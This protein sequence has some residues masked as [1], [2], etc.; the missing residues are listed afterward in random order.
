MNILVTGATGFIGASFTRLALSQGLAVRATGRRPERLA[1]LARLGAQVMEGDLADADFAR[2]L[3][4]GVEVVVHCAGLGGHWGRAAAFEMANLTTTEN[5]VEACLKEQVRRLVYLSSAQIYERPRSAQPVRE[6]QL[7]AHKRTLQAQTRF[8]AEQRVFGAEEFG[9]Q[10]LA[11]RPA[12]VVGEGEPMLWPG[13]FSLCARQ[14]LNILGNGLNRVCFTTQANLDQALL[15][16]VRAGDEALGRV[17][18]IANGAPVPFWDV[19][20]YGLRQLQLPPL[21]RYRKV[22]PARLAAGLRGCVHEYWPGRPRPSL[23]AADIAWMTED[24]TLDISRARH[25]LG[26][27]PQ[28]S[29]W[30]GMDELCR[31]WRARDTSGKYR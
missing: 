11:L 25:H 31:G 26:Y 5:I 29:L 10:V 20:N 2:R 14:R 28:A 9:L 13:L 3:C 27:Q 7:P 30:S 23:L 24:F 18:N 17:Y 21:R 4:Q 16:A 1:G 8:R 6:D 12:P 15:A 22:A 19:L